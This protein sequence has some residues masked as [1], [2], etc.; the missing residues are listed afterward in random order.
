[1]GLLSVSAREAAQKGLPVAKQIV[2]KLVDD[3]DGSDADRTVRFSLD[4]V[5]YEIDLSSRLTRGSYA[6]SLLP[7][8]PPARRWAAEESS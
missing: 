2:H 3:L 6:T 5:Q 7:T 1:M 4:G 8:P